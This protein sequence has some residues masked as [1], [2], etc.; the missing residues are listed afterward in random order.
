M[1]FDPNTYGPVMAVLLQQAR[2]APLGPGQP[3][4]TCRSR[5]AQLT[6]STAFAHAGVRDADMADCCLAGLWLYHDYLDEGHTICQDIATSSGSYWHA[7][8]HRREGDFGNSGY[9]FRRVGQHPI[10]AVL[11]T[12]AARLAASEPRSAAAFLTQQQSWDPFA[13]ID[14]CEATVKG[15]TNAEP[16]CRAVQQREWELLF[17]YCYRK[18]VGG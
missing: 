3:N 17:D 4:E 6:V 14:F 9:W 2:L 15:R 1:S 8:M 12:E 18:A 10:F 11:H 7:I 13:F 16:L 5:L